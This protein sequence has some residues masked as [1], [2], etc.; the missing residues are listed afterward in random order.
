[1]QAGLNFHCPQPSLPTARAPQVLPDG[2]VAEACEDIVGDDPWNAM[3]KEEIGEREPG[4]VEREQRDGEDRKASEIAK[5]AATEVDEEC[6]RTAPDVGK[7]A[8]DHVAIEAAIP[9]D[10][11]GSDTIKSDTHEGVESG[12]A[13]EGG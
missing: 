7:R 12:V 5:D 1:M 3:S 10:R 9:K 4:D 2:V 8:G 11:V 13:F 6:E